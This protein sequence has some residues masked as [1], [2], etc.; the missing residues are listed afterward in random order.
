MA[1]LLK[2]CNKQTK[3]LNEIKSAAEKEERELEKQN[4]NKFDALHAMYQQH[5]AEI[6]SA[7]TAKQ[8]NQE[9]YNDTLADLK[10]AQETFDLLKEDARK[11]DE[12]AQIL[13]R[14]NKEF[15]EK[16]EK[17]NKATSYIQAH[18][19]GMVARK[20]RDKAMKGKK[21]RKGKKK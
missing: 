2:E 4:E 18:Y 10:V 20:E 11:R 9:D 8:K 5:D 1:K 13:E 7:E 19:M 12:V 6:T 15:T 3:A 16:M 21:K 14:K 17:L